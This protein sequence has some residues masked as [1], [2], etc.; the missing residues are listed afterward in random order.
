M[1]NLEPKC[2]GNIFVRSFAQ[3]SQQESIVTGIY[4]YIYRDL[5]MGPMV[6]RI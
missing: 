6:M 2:T 5:P 4:V 1:V 3:F